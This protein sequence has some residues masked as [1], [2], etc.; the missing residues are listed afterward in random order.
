MGFW[1]RQFALQRTR[2]QLVFDIVFGIIA[3]VLCFYF[4]PFLF[5]HSSI[6]GIGEGASFP[7]FD[8]LV[9]SFA[10][11]EISC[12]IFVMMG[13][14][15][16]G[17]FYGFAAGI[18]AVGTLFC[19]LIGIALVPFSLMGLFFFLIG[20]LGFTPFVAGIVYLR[21]VRRAHNLSKTQKHPSGR[22]APAVLGIIVALVIPVAL[23]K[24]RNRAVRQAMAQVQS[25]DPQLVADG[26]KTLRFYSAVLPMNSDDIVWK[27]DRETDPVKKQGLARAYHAITGGDVETQLQILTASID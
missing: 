26:L 23:H 18:L 15:L 10:A 20:L 9:Y 3:P 16:P 19:F 25:D 11:I 4:D 13:P 27:Y 21:N 12:L 2:P 7:Q 22:L 24:D 17:Y 14:R 6:W 8:V 5:R 1:G